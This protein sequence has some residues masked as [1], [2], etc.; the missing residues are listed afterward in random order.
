MIGE[1]SHVTSWTTSAAVS[2]TNSVQLPQSLSLF[3]T[4][5]NTITDWHV[6]R[7]MLI[8]SCLSRELHFPLLSGI[9]SWGFTLRISR[10]WRFHVTSTRRIGS[11]Y[12]SIKTF[13]ATGFDLV[14][15]LS[16][17]W[18]VFTL[19]SLHFLRPLCTLETL[20]L[21]YRFECV[22]G[23]DLFSMLP[24][25]TRKKSNRK[26]KLQQTGASVSRKL[27]LCPHATALFTISIITMS[28]SQK[29]WRNLYKAY[30]NL[31]SFVQLFFF[32]V[33]LYFFFFQ[34]WF[35]SFCFF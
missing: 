18:G 10:A 26:W 27:Y 12:S 20:T 7:F 29:K 23:E 4:F 14:S 31:F 34:L 6:F 21:A 30:S 1:H 9:C 13:Q 3:V 5:S 32:L 8:L 22:P 17:Y 15:H 2:S 25:Q 28:R 11:V 19:Q 24:G 16:R 35:V 33:L